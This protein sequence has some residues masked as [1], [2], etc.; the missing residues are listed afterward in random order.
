MTQI[1]IDIDPM[2]LNAAQRAM[3]VGTPAEAVEAAFR[4]VV[5]EARDRGR[6]FMADPAN[7][8]MVAHMV[9]EE[10]DRSLRA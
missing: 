7:W 3:R 5:Q 8:P 1:T 6:A 10:H 9:D 2:L 4:Q